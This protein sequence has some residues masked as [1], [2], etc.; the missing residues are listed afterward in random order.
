MDY[1]NTGEWQV[2]QENLR[3]ITRK[4]LTYCPGRA[5]LFKALDRTPF[6]QV[7]VLII[8][9]D[10]YP[11]ILH[12]TGVAFE[13]PDEIQQK[14]FP[15]TLK[16]IFAEYCNDLHFP[17]P[18]CGSLKKWTDQGVLLWNAFPSCDP[19]V[20]GSHNWD[21]WTYLTKE[22]VQRTT[23]EGIVVG[24]LGAKAR[25]Y[26][27]YIDFT[28]SEAIITS[29]PSPRGNMM[30]SIHGGQSFSGSRFFSTVNDK[31]AS[32]WGKERVIDWRL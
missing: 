4:R 19:G 12:A 18:S 3:D 20:P 7:K 13:V 8:G 5:N 24:M 17:M 14:N 21:E 2:V 10:P 27:Q 15:A 23:A 32:G 31:L 26:S 16:N 1:W 29:H 9:Q 28:Q 11:N 30:A 22:I 25:Y 6:D